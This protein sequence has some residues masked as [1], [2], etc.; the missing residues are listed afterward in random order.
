[1]VVMVV[2]V[3]G[4]RVRDSIMGMLMRMLGAGSRRLGMG[5][6]VV[7]I[8]V[9]VLVSMGDRVVGVRVR[10]LSHKNLLDASRAW[11][12]P[13]SAAGQQSGGRLGLRDV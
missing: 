7:L 3:V 2:M 6:V 8:V 13:D 12:G 4:M 10:M 11:A 9:G 1:M 5:V